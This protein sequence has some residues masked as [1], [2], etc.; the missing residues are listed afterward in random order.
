MKNPSKKEKKLLLRFFLCINNWGFVG[1]LLVLAVQQCGTRPLLCS[2]LRFVGLLSM[3]DPPRP[4]VPEAVAKCR[5]AGIKVIM[6]TGDHPITA[7]AIARAVGIISPRNETVE[8]IALR[9]GIDVSL[10]DP[11]SSSSLIG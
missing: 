1:F 10:V 3:I 5:L 8:D 2:D 4:N 9:K 7:K 11:R 6:V